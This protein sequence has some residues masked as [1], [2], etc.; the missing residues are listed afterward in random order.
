M[1]PV[2]SGTGE[3]NPMEAAFAEYAFASVYF[4]RQ[5]RSCFCCAHALE[6]NG[7]WNWSTAAL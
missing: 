6:L 2:N 7:A 5:G 4:Y 3:L 1:E